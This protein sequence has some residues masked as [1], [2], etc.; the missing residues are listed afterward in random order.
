MTEKRE[1]DPATVYLNDMKK[2]QNG[3]MALDR[4]VTK[5][6]DDVM[7]LDREREFKQTRPERR[8]FFRQLRNRGRRRQ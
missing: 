8:A 6:Q 3:V 5:I 4:E 2:I 7:D 1:P